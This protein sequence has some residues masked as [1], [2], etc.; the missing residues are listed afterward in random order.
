MPLNPFA[1]EWVPGAAKQT[2]LLSVDS[3]APAENAQKSIEQPASPA[4]AQAG[5]S[6]QQVG[7]ARCPTPAAEKFEEPELQFEDVFEADTGPLSP[8]SHLSPVSPGGLSLGSAS[9]SPASPSGSPLHSALPPCD[10]PPNNSGE[11]AGVPSEFSNAKVGPADFTLMRVVGQGAFG[12]VFQVQ[13]KDTGQVYAM[14]VMRKEQIIAKDHGDYVKAERNVLTAVFH[15][16]IVTLRCS[17]QT[18]SKLYLVLD[19]INGGHLFFQLYRQGIFDEQLARLYTA[20]IVLAIAHL[21][22]L[23]FV[24]RDLK[25]ENVLLDSEGHIKITDFGL[26]KLNMTEGERT[27]SFI[28][29]ME[30]M[31]PE[32]INGKGHGKDVDW[33]SVGILLFEMLTGMP[34]FNAKSRNQL[35]KQI[36]SGKLKYPTFMSRNA[37]SLLKGLLTRDVDKRLGNGAEGSKAVMKH[38]FFSS[39]NWDKLQKREIPSP[40]KPSTQGQHSVEN[41]DKMW[42]EQ[43][44]TDS[45]AGTPTNLDAIFQGYSYVAPH[46]LT[47]YKQRSPS[48]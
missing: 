12:K 38:P 20:E 19:F 47:G 11:I 45:P 31:A 43:S 48:H 25:P 9:S 29:T 33:W 15:P 35:Q 13:K 18:S 39:I 28:G 10:L 14:K 30:Y 42:T 40:F 22:S 8:R 6:V 2:S 34:P 37:Q 1:R 4:A 21:H 32:V 3:R 23:G 24:H 44:P 27:N 5:T 41:F 17:F 26:A 7:S 36:V 46:M 16:Y